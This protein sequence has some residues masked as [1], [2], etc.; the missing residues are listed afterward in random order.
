[1]NYNRKNKL[2]KSE[3]DYIIK[4][5]GFIKILSKY[6]KPKIVG[7][8]AYNL[9]TWRDFDIDLSMDNTNA[10]KIY[11]L[12]KEVALSCNPDKL[13]IHNHLIKAVRE[14]P[15]GIWVGIYFN[16]WKIDLWL[17]TT[18][19]FKNNHLKF[20]NLQKMLENADKDKIM[21]IKSK[22]YNHPEYHKTFSSVDIYEAVANY[23]V[24]SINEF[25][26]WL[27]INKNLEYNFNNY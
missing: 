24:K 6:G 11:S 9:M 25:E 20:I 7:S 14:R 4:Q 1:M 13:Q 18:K 19:E 16:N 23:N 22:I 12:I 5:T 17:L 15:K 26:K 8:Y 21:E 27:K 3:I 2:L 10:E